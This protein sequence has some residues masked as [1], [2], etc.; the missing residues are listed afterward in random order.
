MSTP[1]CRNS[2]VL[3]GTGLADLG[4]NTVDCPQCGG[5]N[6]L[7]SGERLLACQFCSASLFVDRSGVVGHYFLPRL[8][9]ADNAVAALKRWMAGNE[10]VKDLDSRS[11]IEPPEPVSFPVWMFR[12]RAKGGAET[13]HIEPAAPTPIPQLAD[14]KVPAG[15]LRPFE[16]ESQDVP[17]AEATI[18]L[19]TARKW[20]DERG[21]D[22]VFESSLVELP[23]WRCGYSYEGGSFQAL[24]DGSTGAVM[25]AVYPE[26]AEAPYYLIAAAGLIL[27]GIE[28]LLISNPLIKLVVYAIT[29]VPLALIAYWVA[30]KV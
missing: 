21:V 18:P 1:S 2:S 5:E 26:K 29:G 4:S 10:T 14:L 13:A 8:L 24:V 30:R 17:R 15:Q 19:E 7:P 27:F 23:L 3:R 25:A 9:D 28:G 6:P 12:S 11:T 20:L 16:A 22:G